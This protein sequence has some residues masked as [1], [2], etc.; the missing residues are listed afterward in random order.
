MA[1]A[2]QADRIRQAEEARAELERELTPAQEA[3]LTA[4]L[5]G[6]DQGQAAE[7]AGVTRQTVNGWANHDPVFVARMNAER[8][9]AWAARVERL[10]ALVG[11]AVDVLAD[12]LEGDDPKAARWAAVHI[13]RAVGL[14][15]VNAAPVGETTPAA[16]ASGWKRAEA[17]EAM[18]MVWP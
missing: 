6:Q 7:A 8:R 9:A 15:G 2:T 12:D 4:L 14:Y 5:A 3:A 13:L 1:R 16:V 18:T 11:Q 17:L 10:R